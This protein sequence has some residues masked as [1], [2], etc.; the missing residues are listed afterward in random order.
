VFLALG[1]LVDPV[2]LLKVEYT[3]GNDARAS[4][5]LLSQ[6]T[7]PEGDVVAELGERGSLGCGISGP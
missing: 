4:S 1:L 6:M 3:L 5:G 2:S 7:L